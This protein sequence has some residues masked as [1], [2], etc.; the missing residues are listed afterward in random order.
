M[1]SAWPAPGVPPA[2]NV[3]VACALA[4]SDSGWACGM[5]PRTA[6]SNVTGTPVKAARCP[7]SAVPEPLLSLLKSAVSVE[8]PLV[9][10]EV[11]LA[12]CVN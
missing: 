10:I 9:G 6:L 1:A 12:V 5:V 11:G 2:L 7:A 8:V 3:A 4:F